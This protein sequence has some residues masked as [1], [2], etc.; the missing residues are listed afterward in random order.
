[1]ANI[2]FSERIRKLRKDNSLT[3]DELAAKLTVAKSSVSMWENNG[4]VPR[5]EILIQ[6]SA[7]YNVSIDYLLGNEQ[8][9]IVMFYQDEY[10]NFKKEM[11][12]ANEKGR[13]FLMSNEELAGDY[14]KEAKREFPELMMYK[15]EKG[16]YFCLNDRA[17]KKLQELLKQKIAKR[18]SEI[19]EL[20]TNLSD[21]EGD[22]YGF[23][24]KKNKSN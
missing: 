9:G 1:M 22:I 20:K 14:W 5:P 21:I 23:S 12:A 7:L 6:L 3:M 4:T 11:L 18:E 24:Y 15:I 19:A 10:E 17:K 8:K 16:Q 2:I 13:F